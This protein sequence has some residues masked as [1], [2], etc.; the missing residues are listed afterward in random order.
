MS[1]VPRYLLALALFALGTLPVQ[2][3]EQTRAVFQEIGGRWIDRYLAE[4]LDGLMDLYTEDAMVMLHGKPM[5]R[6][7]PAIRAFFADSLG[8]ASV[9]F[10][11]DVERAEI[12]GAMA[13]LISKYWMSIRPHGSDNTVTDVG[14]SLLIYKKGS[15]GEWRIHADIDQATPDVTWPPPE[16]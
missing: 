13:Y 12:H 8:K 1:C 16:S 5:M 9:T 15:D 2:A 7:K 11:I 6:G 4:D 10:E 14:R 3:D